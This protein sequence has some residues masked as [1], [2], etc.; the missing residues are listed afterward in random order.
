MKTWL[1]M[2]HLPSG[3]RC[4]LFFFRCCNE[5]KNKSCE[6]LLQYGGW[7]G[8]G[9]F[10]VLLPVV[11]AAN[12][13]SL[14]R[15]FGIDWQEQK[16]VR[17]FATFHHSRS[18]R[19]KC[20]NIFHFYCVSVVAEGDPIYWV[21]VATQNMMASYYICNGIGVST[22]RSYSTSFPTLLCR[23]YDSSKYCKSWKFCANLTWQ[24]YED[25]MHGIIVHRTSIYWVW[26]DTFFPNVRTIYRLWHRHI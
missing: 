5:N 14:C 4:V 22:I 6:M 3:V 23:L 19:W 21:L 9:F 20:A 12:G 13:M 11:F 26:H 7:P 1:D 8:T 24:G 18:S 16:A 17:L 25:I 2:T 15:L 10:I